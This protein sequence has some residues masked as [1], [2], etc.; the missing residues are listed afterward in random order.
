MVFSLSH[1]L[2]GVGGVRSVTG[3]VQLIVVSSDGHC[4]LR[5]ST[6]RCLVGRDSIIRIIRTSPAFQSPETGGH[7]LL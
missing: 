6:Q 2:N 1:Y 7:I 4:R 5:T 3:N